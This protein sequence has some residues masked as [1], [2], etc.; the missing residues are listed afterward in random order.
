[1][2][3]ETLNFKIGLSRSDSPKLPAFQI[4]INNDIVIDNKINKTPAVTEYFH[5]IVDI[6]ES[7]NH[8]L[9]I[10]FTNKESKD[11]VVDSDGNILND[12]LLNID[13]IEINDVEL[14][15]L[16]RKLSKYRPNYPEH[17]PDKNPEV[18]NCLHLGWNGSWTLEFN[19]PFYI[20]LLDNL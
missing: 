11:T 16:K 7:N 6:E 14:R 4:L 2:V 1:M 19:V 5:F 13:S 12:L 17:Y 20:W 3:K 15:E 9:T 8:S 10:K 18:S